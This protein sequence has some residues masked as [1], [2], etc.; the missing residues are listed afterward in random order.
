MSKRFD[1]PFFRMDEP[2]PALKETIN[3]ILDS[4]VYTRGEYTK[5]FEELFAEYLGTP[6]VKAVCSGTTALFVALYGLGVEN[7]I[8]IIPAISFKATVDAVILAKGIPLVID[9]DETYTMDLN[10]LEDALKKYEGKVAAILPVHLFG[11]MADMKNIMEISR[12]YGVYVIEDAAQ[13]H[14]SHLEG[15]KAGSWGDIGA[16]SFY[17]TKN[18]T[19]GE[20][21]ALSLNTPSVIK[22]IKP[23]LEF[24]EVPAFN[25]RISEFQACI[26]YFSL[27]KLEKNVFKRRK[28][29]QI[30][31][32]GL[33]KYFQL[34]KERGFHS[35]HVFS[36]QHPK[37]DLI[38]K[39]LREKGIATKIYYDYTLHGLRKTLHYPT[40]NAEKL[41]KNIFSLPIYPSLS[42]EQ[43]L[44]IVEVLK[45][46]VNELV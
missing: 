25:F 30:Y 14:G 12:K 11:N 33:G 23:I 7:K 15:K 24:G 43:A 38:I 28:I 6:V 22:K 29:A 26:G 20:G 2:E 3:K 27:L 45:E 34:Q 44:Y 13:A 42:E 37:R 36:L 21:G 41:V 1:I 19:M 8:V 18:A 39:K 16:F 35:Y 40:P 5:K 17:A 32:E 10:Q 46:V 9:I 4:G 31:K